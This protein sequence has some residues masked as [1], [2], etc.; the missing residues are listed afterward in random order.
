LDLCCYA[1]SQAVTGSKLIEWELGRLNSKEECR[2]SLVQ[3]HSDLQMHL[4]SLRTMIETLNTLLNSARKT[5]VLGES[6]RECEASRRTIAE[7]LSSQ[8]VRE[9]KQ[10]VKNLEQ[11]SIGSEP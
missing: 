1:A 5:L 11:T 9:L 6:R 7:L 10:A 2:A 4:E 3:E 8:D